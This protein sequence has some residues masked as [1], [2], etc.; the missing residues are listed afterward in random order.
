M[1]RAEPVA[2]TAGHAQGRRNIDFGGDPMD[3]R[4]PQKHLVIHAAFRLFRE[5]LGRHS[6]PS[7]AAEKGF[8]TITGDQVL[9]CSGR[10][11]INHIAEFEQEL[12]GHRLAEDRILQWATS[13]AAGIVKFAESIG[14]KPMG[15]RVAR[16]ILDLTKSP[17][18]AW[19]QAQDIC[20]LCLKIYSRDEKDGS[21]GPLYSE[22]NRRLRTIRVVAGRDWKSAAASFDRACVELAD[23][24]HLAWYGLRAGFKLSPPTGQLVLTVFRGAELPKGALEIYTGCVG[25]FVAW[26][27]FTSF[28]TIRSVAES[29][30]RPSRGGV[31][32]VFEL[33]T[34]GRPR[35]KSLSSHKREEEL[36]LHPFS[37]LRVDAVEGGVVKLTEVVVAQLANSPQLVTNYML[38]TMVPGV[39][40]VETAGEN[41][42][43]KTKVEQLNARLGQEQGKV[44]QLG[45]Q[46][47]KEKAKAT[48]LERRVAELEAA[49]LTSSFIGRFVA[50]KNARGQ[51]LSELSAPP[52]AFGWASSR[53][54][55]EQFIWEATEEGK[56]VG[57]R[58]YGGRVATAWIEASQPRLGPKWPQDFEAGELGC[59]RTDLLDGVGTW[60]HFDLTRQGTKWGVKSVAGWLSAAGDK[61][62]ANAKTCGPNE[63]FEILLL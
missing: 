42:E 27:A 43:L 52:G 45:A 38:P 58:T 32:V 49:Q 48:A 46:L 56:K 1:F 2:A 36:L 21:P 33:K 5:N 11:D 40:T 9:V 44:A 22:I 47:G 10:A 55:S 31:G 19:E 7:M 16:E 17:G 6:A 25:R 4:S 13:A 54:R 3:G 30:A 37:A 41:A 53:G 14:K 26:G 61:V 51:F 59:F 34:A 24:G 28:T 50:I 20:A 23:F 60:E 12:E 57:L 8:L 18:S 35:I 63:L 39:R 62:M 15:E 29:F